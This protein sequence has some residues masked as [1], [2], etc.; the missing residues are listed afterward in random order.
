[1]HIGDWLTLGVAA[2]FVVFLMYWRV[3]VWRA[4]MG[5]P[6]QKHTPSPGPIAGPDKEKLINIGTVGADGSHSY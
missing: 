3:K 1:M 6:K 2:I 5:A 4:Y